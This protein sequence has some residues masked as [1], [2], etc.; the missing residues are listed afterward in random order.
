M[1]LQHINLVLEVQG[2][3]IHDFGITY[4]ARYTAE[5]EGVNEIVVDHDV[6]VKKICPSLNDVERIV[7]MAMKA[8]RTL[9]GRSGVFWKIR[10]EQANLQYTVG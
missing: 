7:D 8:L 5:W 1:A 4:E 6:I 9:P 2:L 3:H 10:I